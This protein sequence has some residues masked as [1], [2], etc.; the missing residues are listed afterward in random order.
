MTVADD[1]VDQIREPLTEIL[2][3]DLSETIDTQSR[4]FSRMAKGALERLQAGRDLP[5]GTLQAF[6][7][8]GSVQIQDATGTARGTFGSDV[9]NCASDTREIIDGSFSLNK[10][11]DTG[12]QAL[13]QF[14]WQRER[15]TSDTALAGYF[16]GGYYSRTDV[17]GLGDGAID[18]FGVNG[19][20]YGA[21]GFG[22]GLFL[23]YYL[24]GAAGRHSFDIDFEAA[25]APINATGQYSYLAGFAGAGISGQREF[26]RFVM[27]PRVGID[28]AYALAGDADVTAKQL[29]L[30][31]TGVIKLD[32]FRGARATAEIRFE[33]LAAPGGSE[34]MADMMRTAFTPRFTC[35]LSSY[36]EAADCGVGLA[37]AWERTD[38]ASGLTWGFEIDAEQID[39]TRRFTF[40][41][42]RERPIANGFGSVVTRLSMPAAQTLQLEHGLKLDW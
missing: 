36:E 28:F 2:E 27:K 4:A 24:A 12:V 15:F 25:P 9:Y 26:D 5:C 21:R 41:I 42:K 37:F 33:S 38:A 20:V 30:T 32:D 19:G 23:D 6:D 13:F 11:E 8:D 35:T 29:G 10:T 3:D 40:N 17:S 31:H 18:G 7:V 1:L 39:E 22:Q 14:A 16:L 34:A